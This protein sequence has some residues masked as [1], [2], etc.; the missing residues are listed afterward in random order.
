[1]K[2]IDLLWH[3]GH[4]SFLEKQ[5]D[6]F[7]HL[8]GED[9]PDKD[10]SMVWCQGHA[11]AVML[12]TNLQENGIKVRLLTDLFNNTPHNCNIVAQIAAPL[13]TLH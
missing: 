7:E 1:M 11:E 5:P 12:F 13:E 6:R 2:L 8:I 4:R 3:T 9:M 10:S